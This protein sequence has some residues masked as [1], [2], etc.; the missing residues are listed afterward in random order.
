MPSGVAGSFFDALLDSHPVRVPAGLRARRGV[1]ALVAIA[2]LPSYATRWAR[3]TQV[4]VALLGAVALVAAN[5]PTW[6]FVLAILVLVVATE[7]VLEVVRRRPA[8]AH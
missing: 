7:V 3:P 8:H 1:A 2:S 5:D 4:G 6:A